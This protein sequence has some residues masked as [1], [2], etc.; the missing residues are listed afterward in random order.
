MNK[1]SIIDFIDWILNVIIN[2]KSKD[3]LIKYII[4]KL[5]TIDK[6]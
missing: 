1:S 6:I 3:E 4:K 5:N 2:S